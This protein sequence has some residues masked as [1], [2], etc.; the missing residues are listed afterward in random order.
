MELKK[1]TIQLDNGKEIGDLLREDGTLKFYSKKDLILAD[2]RGHLGE[3]TIKYDGYEEWYDHRLVLVDKVEETE[4]GYAFMF[5]DLPKE[6]Y[7][8]IGNAQRPNE[9]RIIR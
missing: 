8:F 1:A 5:I 7:E 2:L 6:T 3:V 4:H 9:A